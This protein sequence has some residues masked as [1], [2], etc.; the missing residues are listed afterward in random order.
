MCPTQ[1]DVL[2]VSR[3]MMSIVKRGNFNNN[4]G[5]EG[6]FLLFDDVRDAEHNGVDI[7]D[8]FDT[9]SLNWSYPPP[10]TLIHKHTHCM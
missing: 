7:V 8:I 10:S 1:L 3:R 6:R 5:G 9:F 2:Y 4:Y